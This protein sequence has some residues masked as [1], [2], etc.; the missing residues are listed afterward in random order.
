[1]YNT[2][3]PSTH[4]TTCLLPSPS[5]FFVLLFLCFFF[6]FLFFCSCT[7]A[8]VR[9]LRT[10]GEVHV[11]V[12][13]SN[14]S[15]NRRCFFRVDR[16]SLLLL[17]FVS[18]FFRLYL[19]V[20]TTYLTDWLVGWLVGWGREGEREGERGRE[21]EVDRNILLLLTHLTIFSIIRNPKYIVGRF[22]AE[23]LR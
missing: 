15:I 14:P 18:L 21:R 7:C 11:F 13:Y 1:M 19:R 20:G 22:G 4:A 8:C 16:F 2:I 5:F 23:Y 3:Y 6:P 10:Y 9:V 17:L 12:R